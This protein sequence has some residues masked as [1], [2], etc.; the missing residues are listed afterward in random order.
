MGERDI[1]IRLGNEE[2]VIRHRY[3][4]LSIINDILVAVWFIVGSF[5]FFSPETSTAGTWLFVI[6]SFQLLLRPAIR[7]VR[8]IHVQRVSGGPTDAG[9]DY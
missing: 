1:E 8:H 7:L 5:L 9:G 3:E 6:G 2:I 4:V